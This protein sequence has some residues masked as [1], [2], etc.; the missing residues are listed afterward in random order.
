MTTE[1]LTPEQYGSKILDSLQAYIIQEERRPME[2]R[3]YCYASSYE[4]CRRKL[5]LL[6]TDGDKLPPFEPDVLARFHRGRDRERNQKIDLEKAGQLCDPPFQVVGGQERFELRDRK[7]RPA[8]VG[9]VDFAV[10]FGRDLATAPV[11]V[12]DWHPNLTD[13]LTT[14]QD[15]LN[16]QW[17]RRGG[18]QLLIYLYGAGREF[19]FLLLPRPG[20]PKL[21]PV[22]LF[23]HL[24]MVEDFLQM[25]EEALD[26]REAGTLPG[27]IEDASECRRCGFYGAVCN[28]PLTSGEG[29]VVLTDPE[30]EAALEKREEL[31]EAADE[32]ASLD[33]QVKER[34]RGVE[35]GVAGKYVIQ[36]RWGSQTSYDVPKE[37]REKYK[38]TVEK[39]RFTLKITKL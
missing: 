3:P 31:K 22:T 37:I 38:K 21:I 34:L 12:K 39:G 32:Y 24:D 10:D 2:R 15:V 8:I 4:P 9:R 7:G 18:Y 29:L 1:T 11:E 27:Y 28:P 13:R 35:T 33:K 25:A 19:G 23:D 5:T 20:L 14:F 6:L 36:G 26:H 17:A 16:N 30:L